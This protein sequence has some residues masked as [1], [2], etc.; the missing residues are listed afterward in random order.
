MI[1]KYSTLQEQS[2][3]TDLQGFKNNNIQRLCEEGAETLVPDLSGRLTQQT[4]EYSTFA[5]IAIDCRASLRFARN[6]VFYNTNIIKKT[7]ND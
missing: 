6:D 3:A 1:N 2:A 5:Y 4:I 7:I